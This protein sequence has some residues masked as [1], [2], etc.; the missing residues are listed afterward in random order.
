MEPNFEKNGKWYVAEASVTGDYNL[1]IERVSKGTLFISQCATAD[2]LY[3]DSFCEK[4]PDVIDHAFKHGV[5][6]QGGLRIK[7]LSSSEITKAVL[8]Y[9]AE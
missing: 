8:N 3:A 7:I 6:P 4:M 2:G 5:Y 1:H 9:G